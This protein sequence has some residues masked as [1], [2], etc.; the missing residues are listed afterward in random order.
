MMYIPDPRTQIEDAQDLD[1]D[2]RNR[3]MASKQAEEAA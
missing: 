3:A 2:A 1:R